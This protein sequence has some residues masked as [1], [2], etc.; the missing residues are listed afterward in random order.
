MPSE[1]VSTVS[2][3][4][5]AMRNPFGSVESCRHVMPLDM[6]PGT[7]AARMSADIARDRADIVRKRDEPLAACSMRSASAGGNAGRMPVAR[8]TASGNLAGCAV[9]RARSSARAPSSRGH[10]G[11]RRANR[12]RGMRIDQQAGSA[13]GFGDRVHRPSVVDFVGGKQAAR[14]P[15]CLLV[16]RQHAGFR[17]LAHR[18]GHRGAA[19]ALQLE[20]QTLEIARRPGC[21]C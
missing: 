4:S 6:A 3:R 9:N 15:P 5:V 14:R 1:T 11:P 13:I 21:P 12:D 20:Q 17:K 18:G 7:G 19:A 16:G 2:M 10:F 8:S